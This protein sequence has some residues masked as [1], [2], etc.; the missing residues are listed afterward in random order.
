MTATCT[1]V[2][3]R[4][5]LRRAATAAIA[6]VG[7][8][9]A[10]ATSPSSGAA[11]VPV[12]PAAI[13]VACPGTQ[14]PYTAPT[15]I[16]QGAAA[17]VLSRINLERAAPAR[18]Y[19]YDGVTTPLSPLVPA[20]ATAEQSAQ[21]AAEWDAAN[22]TVAD[23]GGPDP[24]GYSYATGGNAADGGDTAGVDD[25]IM[26]SYGH[27]GAVLSAAP[28]QVAV[29]AACS[30]GG[31]LY[32][33]EEFFDTDQT[34]WTAGQA[35]FAAELSENSV[36]A[37]SGGTV[38]TVTDTEGTG[39]AQDYFPQEPIVAGDDAPYATGADWSCSG[40]A[41]APGTAPVS[42]LPA[43]VVSIASSADGGGYYL[44]DAGGA[45][46]VHGDASF[47]GAANGLTLTAPIVDMA[48]TPDGG[49]YW[50]VGADGG[51]FTYGDAP[52]DGSLPGLGVH[53]SDIVA[54]VPAPGGGGYWLIGADGGVFAFG[55]APFVGS[56]P[57]LGIQV[58]DVVGAVPTANGLG[59]WM[60]GADGGV[61][62]F[63]DAGFV[64]SL[65]GLGVEVHDV[66]GIVSAPTGAGYWLAGA[67]GGVFA[68]GDAP[69]VGSLPALGVRV[70]DVVGITS[71]PEGGG[72]WLVGA[73]GG[74]FAFGVPFYGSD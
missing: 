70:D 45:V 14:C 40:V 73:D 39:P 64:G 47:R 53:V 57:G 16:E 18:D 31:T 19:L 54:L 46:S 32:V 10:L 61:F 36:Y 35:R 51:V 8:A 63:G 71:P 59:Y 23:Y 65:P 48:T 42:P 3:D 67:D 27:A 33:T 7:A 50:L 56:L 34:T 43:P 38:T 11:S 4:R 55:D 41:Y 25:V 52:M 68:L 30:A 58:S 66:V 24:T 22:D 28:T 26:H 20:A 9:A 62:A 72:Y 2:Q 49:G 21:A 29:G 17:D 13:T 44:A 37:Q 12:R 15:A 6:V 5:T 1:R 60:V 69:Y 74:V